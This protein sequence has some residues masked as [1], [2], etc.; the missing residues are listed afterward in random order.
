MFFRREKTRVLSFDEHLQLLKQAGFAVKPSGGGTIV[1][2]GH[3][4]ALVK[5]AG[6]SHPEIGK[7]GIVIGDE[8]GLLVDG[9]YQ[10][11]FLTPSGRK[12]PAQA[13]H[14]RALHDF[15]EDLKESLG[16]TSLYNQALG[17]TSDL[18]LYDR[19]LH[20]DRGVPKRPWE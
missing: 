3:V 17:T 18:H 2:K 11:F 10:K 19:V 5:D 7:A 12:E 8:I 15:E 1:S 14:L 4:G 13:S 6:G 20:R 9:G 16:L